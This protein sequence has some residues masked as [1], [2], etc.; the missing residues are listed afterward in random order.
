MEK[1]HINA[2]RAAYREYTKLL[3]VE[4]NRKPQNAMYRM[5]FS[6]VAL[7]LG[8]T[9]IELGEVM[10]LDRTS[11]CHHF[12]MHQINANEKGNKKYVN[13]YNLGLQIAEICL[14][15]RETMTD[16]L[17]NYL[18]LKSRAEFLKNELHKSQQELKE[19]EKRIVELNAKVLNMAINWKP[20]KKSIK[21][22]EL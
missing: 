6:W 14:N 16:V 10:N 5:A 7:D 1:E 13:H 15:N 8:Y 11:I 17:N 18:K 2:L 19:K 21:I 4:T 3:G 20:D 9:E 22:T 12:K